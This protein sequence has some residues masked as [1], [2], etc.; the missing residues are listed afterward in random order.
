MA[1]SG[2]ARPSRRKDDSLIDSRR[3][4]LA[5]LA[6]CRRKDTEGGASKRPDR[7]TVRTK[8]RIYDE[9]SDVEY[10]EIVAKRRKEGGGFVVGDEGL[11]YTDIGEEEEWNQADANCSD[12]D[13]LLDS[14]KPNK[15]SRKPT[16]EA[17]IKTKRKDAPN[18]VATSL[19]AAAALMGKPKLANMF[20]GGA[21]RN[22]STAANVNPDSVLDDILASIGPDDVDRA[23]QRS[24]RSAAAYTSAGIQ[25]PIP[26]R[27]S[28]PP[29]VIPEVT[30]ARPSENGAGEQLD[31]TAQGVGGG[32]DK[33]AGRA[34]GSVEQASEAG[35]S[36]MGTGEGEPE[37]GHALLASDDNAGPATGGSG[38]RPESE[39]E[40]A[41]P[42]KLERQA[43]QGQGQGQGQ[44]PG[45][46][47]KAGFNAKIKVKAVTE[48]AVAAWQEVSQGPAQV[49][50]SKVEEGAGQLTLDERSLPLDADKKLPF[51]FVDAYED[52]MGGA[53]GTVYLFGKVPL[54]GQFVS[55]CVVVRNMQRCI[56][57]VPSRSD[58]F[59][60]DELQLLEAAVAAGT[61]KFVEVKKRLH[62][63][64][65]DMKEEV[66][67]LL[68]RK[69]ISP[70]HAIDP[71]KRRYS[72]ERSDVPHGEQYY[73]KV[74]YP[75]QQA[76]LQ[77]DSRGEHFSALLGTQTSV[78][79]LLLI[80]RKLMGPCW[81]SI[82]SPLRVAGSSQISHCKLEVCVGSSK[83]ICVATSGKEARDPPPLVVAALNLKTV[84]NHRQNM[85]EVAVASVV[86][87][88]GV[89][90]DRPMAMAEWNRQD[91]LGHF[92]AVRRLEGGIFPA[93]FD[94]DL[95]KANE[96]KGGGVLLSKK[97]SERE[98][99]SFLLARLSKIDA[100]VLVGHN[101]GGFDLHVLLHRLQACK[102]GN[103]SSIGRLKRMHM[104]RLTGGGNVYGGGAAPGVLA[105][106]AGRLLGDTY[107]SSR[108]LLK[109][110]SY[111]LTQL[112]QSQLGH[113]RCELP[114]SDVPAMYTSSA[115]L[116]KLMELGETDAWLSL[117]LMFKLSILPLSRLLTNLSGNLW[118]KTL[119]GARAQRIEYLLLHEFHR[120]KFILPDKLSSKDKD[121]AN[122]EAAAAASSAASAGKKRAARA[123]AQPP[124]E[125]DEPEPEPDAEPDQDLE[126]GDDE[127]TLGGA[128]GGAL[129]EK[130]GRGAVGGA[131]GG[132][133]KKGAS[134]AGG[135]V[136]EPKKGL[137]DKYVV[138]LDFNSLYPSI[139]QE[140][141]ICF[142]SVARS[143]EGPIAPLPAGDPPGVLPQVIYGDTD[144]IMVHTGL[145]SLADVAAIGARIKKEVNKRY[146]LLEIEMDGVFKRMLLLKKKKY[147]AVK[148]EATSDGGY[149]E[150][151]EQKGIDIV[152][153]DWSVVSKEIGNTCLS[154]ILS[155]SPREE[156]V[157][158]IHTQLRELAVK[159]RKG[160]VDVDSYVALRRKQAGLR[161]GCSAGDTVPYVVCIERGSVSTGA[162]GGIAQKARHIDELKA[163]DDAFDVDV[164]YYLAH[165]IHPVVSR[166]CAPIEG[167]D[168]AR[169]A[170][171]LGLDASKF[172]KQAATATTLKEEALLASSSALD[173]DE[174]YRHC[175]A[176]QLTCPS[177]ASRFPFGGVAALL[178]SQPPAAA[179]LAAPPSSSATPAAAA[180]AAEPSPAPPAPSLAPA[181]AG[182]AS[183]A[184]TPE[185]ATDAGAGAAAGAPPPP[186]AAAAAPSE[187]ATH[188]AVASSPKTSA[189]G[190]G[191]AHG[192]GHHDGSPF[193][194]SST[195]Q[196]RGA[197]GP[198]ALHCPRCLEH[199]ATLG[200]RAAYVTGTMLA[201]Q[202]KLRAEEFVGRYYE[203]WM[204]CD[205]ELC[206]CITR[207]VSLRVVRDS[208]RGA[209]CP[210]F[211]RCSGHMARKV[212]EA[213]LYRQLSHFCRLL[214]VSRALAKLA[215]LIGA[216]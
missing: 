45:E 29:R 69:K 187:G 111:G 112:A 216:V 36:A 80:K 211:P 61:R 212:T 214:D 63:L 68:N 51:F 184:A 126:P 196:G 106:I 35:D 134:Y 133:K 203:G 105:C 136:L 205:E 91:M 97:G 54:E 121:R 46:V 57:A 102:V 159:M 8:E 209:V 132:T 13:D 7:Y 2:E 23:R 59:D 60:D 183:A 181:A 49:A 22:R 16:T 77:S 3:S 25:Q 44:G 192:H 109:E 115:S 28:E 31:A 200:K 162:S 124:A 90:V 190:G 11:G 73:L 83:D 140:Y 131:G 152:R 30:P 96:K 55:C 43:E 195:G 198:A 40:D 197:R 144:S 169:I 71:V 191:G 53:P 215:L 170:D 156:V 42:D 204:M 163:S 107:L 101:I 213:D 118:S 86:Y 177:C 135:L 33:E 123:A 206:G 142:T 188:A 9:V 182:P 210:N 66:R 176:L 108:E 168:S 122:S 148:I 208:E 74:Q 117:G 17:G 48:S 139:I 85:N 178:S 79:E 37:A 147:A 161:E 98:L 18:R 41:G 125:P 145:D 207:N 153:R 50:D 76:P 202:V 160:E 167:T 65:A 67:S 89:K 199:E 137:Y 141:N 15:R 114:A 81:L 95:A 146:K 21:S 149:R 138:L 19:S 165:Q 88:Q 12:D 119:Q 193:T 10:A 171:C 20:A 70:P 116:L 93:G 99:L 166:L 6:A 38:A 78:L 62:V 58:V 64:L 103:W 82:S 185:R 47:G 26:A 56:Y 189:A 129:G 1:E 173:D 92:S 14:A 113:T 4:A 104:P 174:R 143:F 155:G 172:H 180:A 120:R 157:E 75:F 52:A 164:E 154:L 39:K 110:V 84:I 34:A 32:N 194:P 130:G 27:A 186:A 100:D 24:R 72:F 175:E 151:T 128:G 201:N 158:A 94:A 127:G 179:A 150:V 5:Q 87:C